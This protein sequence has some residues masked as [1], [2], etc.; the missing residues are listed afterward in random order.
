VDTGDID[1]GWP[2]DVEE[3]V[4]YNGM[5]FTAEIHSSDRPSAS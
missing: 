5:T 3:Q 2:V 1:P 4:T